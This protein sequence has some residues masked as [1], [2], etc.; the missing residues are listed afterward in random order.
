ME[1]RGCGKVLR[2]TRVV[3]PNLGGA[4][5]VCRPSQRHARSPRMNAVSG[6]VWGMAGLYSGMG[7]AAQW[8]P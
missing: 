8:R 3:A 7:L 2:V 4:Q 6:W 1:A 5:R